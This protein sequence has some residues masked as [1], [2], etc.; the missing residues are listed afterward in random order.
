MTPAFAFALG[1]VSAYR[2]VEAR[3]IDA[4]SIA[5]LEILRG[6][7]ADEVDLLVMRERGFTSCCPQAP[8]AVVV[9]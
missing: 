4:G 2:T 8:A 7:S 9:A 3:L 5:E 6:L 1:A